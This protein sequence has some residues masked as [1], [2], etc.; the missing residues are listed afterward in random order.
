MLV[1]KVQVFRYNLYFCMIKIAG[2]ISCW[3]QA[4][5]CHPAD[6]MQTFP[7]V[8]ALSFI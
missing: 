7:M 2:V 6:A 8:A 4:E 1:L 3:A 5:A